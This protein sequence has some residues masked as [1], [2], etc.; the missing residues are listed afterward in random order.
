MGHCCSKDIKSTVNDDNRPESPPPSS[1]STAAANGTAASQTNDHSKGTPAHSFSA[2]PF[3]SHYP[4]GVDPSPS[5][6]PK[7]FFKWPF[8][9]PSPAKPIMSA[10]LKRQGTRK[11]KEGTTTSPAAEGDGSGDRQRQ[12]DKTFG[13]PKNFGAKYEL[14][15]EV[16]RGHFGHTCFAKGKKGQMKNMPVAV[17]I[18]S[19]SKVCGMF[20]IFI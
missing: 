4:V 5:W 11:A 15:K 18:I 1:E 17:K 13:Y 8:P 10:M 6:T 7:R 3:G 12:L 20:L 14:G 9:P 16:G 2:S 19:K